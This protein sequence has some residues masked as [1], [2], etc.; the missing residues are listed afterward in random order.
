ML[1]LKCFITSFHVIA[2]FCLPGIPVSPGFDV[3]LFVLPSL[4]ILSRNMEELRSHAYCIRRSTGRQGFRIPLP[5]K[6]QSYRVP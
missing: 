3:I 2:S 5:G 6:S 4:T 1:R